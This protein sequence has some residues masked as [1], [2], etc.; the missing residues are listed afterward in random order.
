MNENKYYRA[1][2]S[3]GFDSLVRNVR[4]EYSS[5]LQDYP[6]IIGFSGGKDSTLVTHLVFKAI[7]ELPPKLRTRTIYILSNDTMVESP[8]VA[9]HVKK[10]LCLIDEAARNFNLPIKSV[11][12]KPR[13]AQTFWS[14]L[15]GKGYPSPNQKMR[16]CT[17]RLKIRP[18]SK[19][20]LE[21]ISVRGAAIIVLGVR[22]SESNSRRNVI[23]KYHNVGNSNLSPHS[24]L[25]GAFIYR[26]VVDVET[27]DVWEYLFYHDPPWGGTHEELIR[28]YKNAE[29]GECPLVF[30]PDDSPSCGNSRFGCWVCT[31]VKKDRSLQGFIDSGQKRYQVLVDFRDWLKS[32]RDNPE[33]RHV[34]RR[35]GNLSFDYN[36]KHIPGP[37]TIPSR[38]LILQRLLAVQDIYGEPLISDEELEIIA[39][40]WASELTS[41][42]KA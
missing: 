39:S 20:V 11:V 33:L 8:F 35:N 9:E 28:L 1:F 29:G 2:D 21:Q 14:L 17:D 27:E 34:R 16:W 26:P 12:T 24:D 10:Q 22:K 41:S 32:I 19:F 25:M 6:W 42:I 15:I 13:L 37:F 40:T 38:K 5:S 30:T 18:T 4:N 31:V 7:M 3:S 23:E 36:G